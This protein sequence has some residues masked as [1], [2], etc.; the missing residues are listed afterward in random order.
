MVAIAVAVSIDKGDIWMGIGSYN[1]NLS[2]VYSRKAKHSARPAKFPEP[3]H[4]TDMVITPLSIRGNLQSIWKTN[5]I[6]LH[7][8][9]ETLASNVSLFL[10]PLD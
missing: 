4:S 7:N 2:Q 9:K 8:T 5:D 10:I 3:N 1:G 6:P